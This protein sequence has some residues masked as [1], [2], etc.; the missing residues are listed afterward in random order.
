MQSHTSDKLTALPPPHPVNVR[1]FTT[2]ARRH[3]IFVQCECCQAKA[4]LGRG[5]SLV[6]DLDVTLRPVSTAVSD[7][8]SAASSAN[9]DAVSVAAAAAASPP[10]SGQVAEEPSLPPLAKTPPRVFSPRSEL[11]PL[12]TSAKHIAAARIGTGRRFGV[13]PPTAVGRASVTGGSASAASAP[14]SLS[15]PGVDSNHSK[16]Q[17]DAAIVAELTRKR[18]R[19]Q[20]VRDFS[21]RTA[22]RGYCPFY[23]AS[24]PALTLPL[25]SSNARGGTSRK[26]SSLNL[27]DALGLLKSAGPAQSSSTP[28]K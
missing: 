28:S 1:R 8:S 23:R 12:Q 5:D 22:H 17:R 3:G 27:K 18:A 19:T 25:A 6:W 7:G 9:V 16:R 14:S 24:L 13:L 4:F 26:R 21:P 11:A 10:A 2:I 15:S 20:D